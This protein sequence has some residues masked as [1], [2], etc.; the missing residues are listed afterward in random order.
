M[1]RRGRG[2]L[3]LVCLVVCLCLLVDY[4]QCVCVWV[5]YALGM[6]MAL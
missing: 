1:R 6:G 4:Y 2:G 3:D 5:V